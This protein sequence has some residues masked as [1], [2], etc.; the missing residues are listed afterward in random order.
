MATIRDVAKSAG[1]GIGTVSRA[2]SGNGYVDAE[3]KARIKQIAEELNYKP[4]YMARRMTKKK[5][6][7]V[8]V[9]L[10]DVATPFLGTFLRYTEME[11]GA[12]GYRTIIINTLGVQGRVSEALD[13]VDSGVLDGIII[14]A[15]VTEEEISRLKKMPA[16]S[17]ECQ[18][19][20]EIPM[21]ASD[22]I[23]GGEIAARTLW[24]NGCKNVL[25]LGIKSVTPVYAACRLEVCKNILLEKGARVTVAESV[26]E[27]FSYHFVE[28]MISKYLD[29]YNQIDGIFTED[30]EAYCC[31]AQAAKRGIRVPRDLKIVGYDGNEITRMI[32]PQV[33][34]IR[35]NL[36]MLAR[37]S[38]D[39]LEKRIEG[40]ETESRYLVP[41]QLEKGGTTT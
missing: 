27:N 2:L 33:T 30:V 25:I 9:V 10:T 16:V 31:V 21:V 38:V 17:L 36:P 37:I 41:V 29:I 3:K 23:H 20:D 5:S 26:G 4:N 22:H 1:V 24:D 35:Q 18:L 19:G 32:S 12:I 28:E 14:N 34:T 40:E 6:G 39:V 15:D 7:I 13:L 11:L 8:G